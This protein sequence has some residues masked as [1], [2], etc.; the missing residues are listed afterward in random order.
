MSNERKISDIESKCRLCLGEEGCMSYLFDETLFNK[1]ENITKCT[2]VVITENEDLP[3]KV[4]HVCVYKLDMWDDFKEQFLK[5][6]QILLAHLDPADATDSI[7]ET[8]NPKRKRADSQ[9]SGAESLSESGTTLQ[10]K[11]KPDETC[12]LEDVHKPEN[13]AGLNSK[14]DPE[15]QQEKTSVENIP[16][17]DEGKQSNE[18]DSKSQVLQPQDKPMLIPMRIRHLGGRRGKMDRRKASTKRW[19]ARK[20]ALLAATG[21]Y[22]SDT[23]SIISDNESKLSPV[24][25]ARAKTNADKEIEKQKRLAKALKNLETDMKGEYGMKYD[26]DSILI[27]NTDSE[28]NKHKTRSQKKLISE[29]VT[30]NE[31]KSLTN[32]VE[33][34]DSAENVSGKEEMIGEKENGCVSK[35]STLNEHAIN[36]LSA[37]GNLGLGIEDENIESFMDPGSVFNPPPVRSELDI[38]D[39]TF[40]VTSTLVLSEPHYLRQNE[41]QNSFKDG[42]SLNV[43]EN[44]QERN[45]DIIDAVQLKRINPKTL[46]EGDEKRNV[47][48]CLNIEVEGTELESLQKV[49]AELAAFVEK[50]MKNKLYNKDL[51]PDVETAPSKPKDSFQTLD[52]QLKAIVETAIRKNIESSSKLRR[53]PLTKIRR[54]FRNQ[55]A[56]TFSPAFVEAAMRSKMF[57]PKVLLMRLDLGKV[58]K[59]YKINNMSL[60]KYQKS[61]DEDIEDR[62]T[63]SN[64]RQSDPPLEYRRFNLMPSDSDDT[65]TWDDQIVT[66]TP[67]VYK[68]NLEL[69]SEAAKTNKLLVKKL[70]GPKG[71]KKLSL[72]EQV[73]YAI[74]K[75][76]AKDLAHRR[77]DKPVCET[78]ECDTT[79]KTLP[80]QSLTEK[81]ATKRVQFSKSYENQ[82]IKLEELH[83]CKYIC[84]I[85]D[86][87]FASLN[88]KEEHVKSHTTALN[89]EVTSK[90]KKPRMMRCKRCHEIVDARLV[91][92][93]TCRS[94]KFHKCYVCNSTFRSEKMLV[95]HLETH[96]ESEFNIENIERGQS[97]KKVTTVTSTQGTI[98]QRA[99]DSNTVTTENC[100]KEKVGVKEEYTCFVCDKIFTDEEI[101]KDHLQQH[102]NDISEDDAS[103]GKEQYQCAICGDT[104]ETEDALENHVEKHLCDDQDDNPNLINV[105]NDSD[106]NKE[107]EEIF[108]CSQCVKEFDSEISLALHIQAHEEELAIAEWQKESTEGIKMEEHY[109]CAICEEVFEN[110]EELAEH[111]DVHNSDSHVCFLCEKPFLSLEDL[112]T[113]VASH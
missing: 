16:V 19:V 97:S 48:R 70:A 71:R 102:C 80:L 64:K 78:V 47:E 11:A 14:E 106:P 24:Q 75:G 104:L 55:K 111:V 91:R 17:E 69:I 5:S 18:V 65:V 72:S 50:D 15:Q 4:C 58:R 59:R 31:T 82:A 76:L 33:K 42:N 25:K 54:K 46:D 77:V 13:V 34:E 86:Q 52:Q 73:L 40:I 3:N 28:A 45:T 81:P 9:A 74:R 60:M 1:L 103:S 32:S 37:S 35:Q 49:Q 12:S 27:P 96:D 98:A 109:L 66:S 100:V 84:G 30:T 63:I 108:K 2:S 95:S 110:E 56:S 99:A 29:K 88:E 8:N 57:Q 90:S 53:D 79:T 62:N 68:N 67:R 105:S 92:V 6:N 107:A 51:H 112:Q 26:S 61:N 21:E 83:P 7:P 101:L 10:K 44:S 85:C 87:T 38:G 39:A 23:D 22:A 113:H 89:S 93:H 41:L 36:S 20:K 43:D 94:A